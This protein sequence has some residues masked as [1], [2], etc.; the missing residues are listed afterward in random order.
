MVSK[1]W[2][3][4]STINIFIYYN[5]KFKG[6]IPGL[7][8]SFSF[9]TKKVENFTFQWLQLLVQT[10]YQQAFDW[11]WYLLLETRHTSL[12]RFNSSSRSRIKSMYTIGHVCDFAQNWF[13]HQTDFKVQNS[14]MWCCIDQYKDDGQ[15]NYKQFHILSMKFYRW[16]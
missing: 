16:D 13:L 6:P 12:W 4:M 10:C 7:R 2:V 1:I 9:V 14:L 5:A 8:L 11:S 3:G 15:H